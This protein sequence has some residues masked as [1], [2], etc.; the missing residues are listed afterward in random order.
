LNWE[1]HISETIE[2]CILSTSHGSDI[3]MSE[4][5]CLGKISSKDLVKML[6]KFQEFEGVFCKGAIKTAF[7]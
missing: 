5:Q 4:T 1:L 2:S 7:T 3:A 6:R